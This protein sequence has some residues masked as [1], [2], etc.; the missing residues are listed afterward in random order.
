MDGG[1]YSLYSCPYHG[2]VSIVAKGPVVKKADF[3]RNHYQR[4]TSGAV[5]TAT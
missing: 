1:V 4:V 3:L 5:F 2:F